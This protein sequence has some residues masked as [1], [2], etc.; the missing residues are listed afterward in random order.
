VS[1]DADPLMPLSRRRVPFGLNRHALTRR[2]PSLPLASG[3]RLAR[4]ALRI[5][6]GTLAA[7]GVMVLILMFTTLTDRVVEPLLVAQDLRPTDAIVLFAAWASPDGFLNDSGLRRSV[8]AARLYK[9]GTAPLVIVSGRNRSDSGPTSR[10][11]ADL[12]IELGVPRDAVIVETD[13]TN[14]HETAVNV[15][16]IAAAR[17]WERLTLLSDGRDM[18]RATAAFR[19]EGMEVVSGADWQWDLR[20]QSGS[21]R[22]WQ[23]DGVLHEWAGLVYYWWKGWI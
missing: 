17:G 11:M 4:L 20:S 1:S 14:T 5:A 2:P 12:L 15:T 19:H 7:V 3:A 6:V 8:A 21:Y 10:L 13:S 9:R 18:R 16:K 23:F 22:L